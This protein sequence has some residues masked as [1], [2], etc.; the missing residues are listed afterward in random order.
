MKR[1]YVLGAILTVALAGALV[2]FY[3]GSE[4]PAGQTPLQSLTPQNMAEIKNAFNAA[5]DDV[6]VLVLLSPT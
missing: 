5:K 6:R 2:Y 4:A 1:K 3:G